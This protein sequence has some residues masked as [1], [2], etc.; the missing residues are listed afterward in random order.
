MHSLL[1]FTIPRSYVLVPV[2]LPLSVFRQIFPSLSQWPMFA[3]EL[4]EPCACFQMTVLRRPRGI[5][6]HLKLAV[7]IE[8][9][10]RMK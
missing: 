7:L 1:R 5:I 2:L 8:D 9:A 6:L 4:I 3:G 10:A